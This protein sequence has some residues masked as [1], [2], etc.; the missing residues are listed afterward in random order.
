MLHTSSMADT[1]RGGSVWVPGQ[2]AARHQK[3]ANPIL[4]GGQSLFLG[5]N[6]APTPV[7]RI[8]QPLRTMRTPPTQCSQ[9]LARFPLLGSSPPGYPNPHSKFKNPP[10]SSHQAT[11]QYDPWSY[12]WAP[13][14]I[15]SCR[16]C[17]TCR[18]SSGWAAGWPGPGRR[19]RDERGL[20][21][22]RNSCSC[23]VNVLF[24]WTYPGNCLAPP[25]NE[26]PKW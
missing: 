5:E 13:L 17:T 6:C 23:F 20:L 4:A 19:F 16:H 10:R 8:P 14:A 25:S 26:V 2:T 3:E 18:S 11:Q 24:F 7:R 12:L 9:C 21:A 15:C 22:L 1:S